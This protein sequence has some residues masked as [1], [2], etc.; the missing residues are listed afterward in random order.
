M[1]GTA[2]HI[3]GGLSPGKVP[4]E[5]RNKNDAG[6]HMRP[7]CSVRTGHQRRRGKERCL[8][9][10]EPGPESLRITSKTGLTPIW[11]IP[12]AI[13]RW[14]GQNVL[15]LR[16]NKEGFVSSYCNGPREITDG[17]VDGRRHPKSSEKEGSVRLL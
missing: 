4:K 16:G 3:L 2:I 8:W 6:G 17:K 9:S 11:T 14:S 10:S 5:V 13:H 7:T 15:Y 1:E 12:E